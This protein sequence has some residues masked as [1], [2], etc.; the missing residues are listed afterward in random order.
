MLSIA[1]WL[2]VL[3]TVFAVGAESTVVTA[4]PSQA[5][6]VVDDADDVP[7]APLLGVVGTRTISSIE[8]R[9]ILARSELPLAAA[10]THAPASARF[11]Q[12]KRDFCIAAPRQKRALHSYDATAPPCTLLT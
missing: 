11:A 6:Y 4:M 8:R 12:Q 3:L 1:R 10:T 7:D 5:S 2:A 9:H